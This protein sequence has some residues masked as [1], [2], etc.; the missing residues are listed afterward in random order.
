MAPT[1]CGGHFG[2]VRF[3]FRQKTHSIVLACEAGTLT[4]HQIATI[5]EILVAQLNKPADWDLVADFI[6]PPLPCPARCRCR[7]LGGRRR[8]SLDESYPER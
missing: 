7:P 8:V 5:G 4:P 2:Y 1:G 6:P 3:E